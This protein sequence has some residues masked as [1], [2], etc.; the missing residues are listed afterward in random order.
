MAYNASKR[1]TPRDTQRNGW[2]S[3]THTTPAPHIAHVA[4]MTSSVTSPSPCQTG[5]MMSEGQVGQAHYQPPE[6]LGT[7]RL[8]K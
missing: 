8:P 7:G 4:R 3:A 6:P 5:Y 1:H 2:L